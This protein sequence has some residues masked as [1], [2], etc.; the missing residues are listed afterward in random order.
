M[1]DGDAK[2]VQCYIDAGVDPNTPS[3]FD[4]RPGD[5]NGETILVD[6]GSH[7]GPAPRR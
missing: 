7:L 5:H 1:W 4:Q 6:A 2:A 3:A